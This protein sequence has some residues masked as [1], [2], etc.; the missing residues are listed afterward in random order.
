M[1]DKFAELEEP[2]KRTLPAALVVLAL[3]GGFT[4]HH[5]SNTKPIQ[6]SGVI[7]AAADQRGVSVRLDNGLVVTATA[8][9]GVP[10][11]N[12]EHVLV[13]EKT[14]LF[15]APVYQITGKGSLAEP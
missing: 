11:S 6:L 14:S 8:S 2:K 3:M 10:L 7:Q 4:I 9:K 1:K 15:A 5:L 12:G 13:L